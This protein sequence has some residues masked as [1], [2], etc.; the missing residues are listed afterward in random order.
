MRACVFRCDAPADVL[1]INSVGTSCRIE[2]G[3]GGGAVELFLTR[4]VYCSGGGVSDCVSRC[5]RPHVPKGPV[6]PRATTFTR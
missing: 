3:R 2:C 4:R 6:G 1:C 5:I